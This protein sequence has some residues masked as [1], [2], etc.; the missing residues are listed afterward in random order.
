MTY[1]NKSEAIQNSLLL[2]KHKIG[3]EMAEK[4]TN[5]VSMRIDDEMMKFL[6]DMAKAKDV[7]FKV[8]TEA[9]ELM[10]IGREALLKKKK[11]DI[12]LEVNYS[13]N[14]LL[15]QG[16]VKVTLN[17]ENKNENN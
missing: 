7:K 11:S 4:K 9:Y 17:K 15:K 16:K 14:I 5:R 2:W 13:L 12:G 3:F 1:I 8:A 10:Q 6:E